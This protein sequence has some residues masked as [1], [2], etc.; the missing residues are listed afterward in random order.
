MKGCIM[1]EKFFGNAAACK[2]I[3]FLIGFLIGLISSSD[4]KVGGAIYP[5]VAWSAFGY[6][7]GNLGY[8]VYG[9]VKGGKEN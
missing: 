3:G 4:M 1:K 7:L 8:A 5:I 2:S 9:I 6:M